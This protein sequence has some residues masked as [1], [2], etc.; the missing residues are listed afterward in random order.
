MTDF[1]KRF[2]DV[3]RAVIRP[4]HTLKIFVNFAGFCE[5]GPGRCALCG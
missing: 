1:E 5:G 4:G 2:D 3:N